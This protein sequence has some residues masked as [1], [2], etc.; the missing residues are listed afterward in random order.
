MSKSILIICRN[1]LSKA[2]RFLMEVEALKKNY[3][4]IALGEKSHSTS[5]YEFV[6][7]KGLPV[8]DFHHHYPFI[9]KKFVSLILKLIY[10]RTIHSKAHLKRRLFNLHFKQVAKYNVDLVIVHHL[11][12]LPLGVKLAKA[13]GSKLIFNAHEYY[14]LEF[15][16]DD[17]WMK[18]THLEYMKIANTYF[19]EVDICF[20]VGQ[21][22]AEKYKKE[23]NLN[24]VVITNSKPY[25]DLNPTQSSG[26]IKLI[27]HGASI[28]ARK[29]ELMIEMMGFLGDNYVLDL[30][31]VSSDDYIDEL[32]LLA[33]NYTN[34]NFIEPVAINDIPVFTN[35]YDIGL[36]LLPP[37]NFNYTYA[38]PNKFFEFIQARLAIAIGPSPEMA[39]LVNK[40][41][42]G[43]V[44][45]DFNP[46][47][48]AKKIKAI[49]AEQIMHYKRQ[50]HN[51]AKE[52]SV[53]SNLMLIANTVEN[54][55]KRN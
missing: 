20:C 21:I 44:A 26:K 36:F 16:D 8:T 31:C 52:L 5:D 47:A 1:D 7:F 10:Y 17:Y 41:D 23:F 2:P 55:I 45:D 54:L 13:N 11:G 24:S 25:Y 38:L 12:D 50:A 22:I 32:K 6:A 42:L 19:K 15:D 33:K 37:T 49:S 30:M 29:I 14:P 27:H 48:L 35:S 28:R 40:Y 4:L 18:T 3:R 46:E 51:C 34:V 53:E 43:V 39:A 9:L